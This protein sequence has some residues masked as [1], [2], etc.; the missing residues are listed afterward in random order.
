M[1]PQLLDFRISDVRIDT[2]ILTSQI[3]KCMLQSVLKLKYWY[4]DITEF[5]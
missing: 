2:E 5:H 3:T 1:L 4:F